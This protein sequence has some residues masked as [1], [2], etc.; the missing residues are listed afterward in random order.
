MVDTV[1]F[2]WSRP[3][4]AMIDAYVEKPYFLSAEVLLSCQDYQRLKPGNWPSFTENVMAGPVAGYLLPYQTDAFYAS[5]HYAFTYERIGARH[6][7]DAVVWSQ[8]APAGCW[9]FMRS[10]EKGPF[11]AAEVETARLV[12]ALTAPALAVTRV[13][14]PSTRMF[15]AGLLVYAPDDTLI[16]HNIAAHQSLWMLAR[17][18]EQPLAAAES[19][20]LEALARAYCTDLL[21]EARKTGG[22]RRSVSNRWGDFAVSVHRG[23]EG[24]VALTFQQR[25]PLAAHLAH[26]LLEADVP[27][28]RMM[29]AWHALNGLSRKENARL[30]GLSVDTVGEYLKALFAQFEVGSITELQARFSA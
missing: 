23:D 28:R 27:P 17:A 29:V 30:S 12:A 24:A 8:G 13:G 25:R 5:H 20:S 2:F 10:A 11:T 3:D 7:L 18:G 22:C 26:S 1:G 21:R 9:L 14:A 16:Y 15:D 4:G 19:D 6:I